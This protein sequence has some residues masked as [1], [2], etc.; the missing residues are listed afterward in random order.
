MAADDTLYGRAD[1]F[2]AVVGLVGG[3]AGGTG[4]A[5]YARLAG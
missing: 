3:L 5:V 1:E 2:R 4:G